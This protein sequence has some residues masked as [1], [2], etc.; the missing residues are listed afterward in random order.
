M[1]NKI[2]NQNDKSVYLFYTF[3][4]KS[5]KVIAIAMKINI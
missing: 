2:R 1:K 5:P 3:T 4:M